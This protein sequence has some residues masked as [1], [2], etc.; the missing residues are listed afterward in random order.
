[1]ITLKELINK[2]EW[3]KIRPR[4]LELYPDKTNNIDGY[5]KAFKELITIEPKECKKNLCI[6]I[7][8]I[9][10]KEIGYYTHVHGI[11]K[12]DKGNTKGLMFTPWN[13]WLGIPIHERSIY[14]YHEIDIICHCLF[15]ITYCGFT[16]NSSEET[17]DKIKNRIL[18][19]QS[20]LKE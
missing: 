20:N 5:E 4:M 3:E 12:H 15:E 19:K 2:Y 14:S 13:E 10:D 16:N 17:K 11:T 6:G 18:S 9:H 1:M 7:D 8:P